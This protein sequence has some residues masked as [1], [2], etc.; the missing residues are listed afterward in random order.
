MRLRIWDALHA[1]YLTKRINHT[2]AYSTDDACTN[3][4][5]SFLAA[6]VARKSERIIISLART[7]RPIRRKW[8]GVRTTGGGATASFIWR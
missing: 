6:C 3:Q 4:A 1:R 8:R 2:L 5:E 7:S